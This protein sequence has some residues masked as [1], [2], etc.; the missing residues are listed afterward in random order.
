MLGGGQKQN[1]ERH[2][3]F[4]SPEQVQTDLSASKTRSFIYP[5]A[6]NQRA[7]QSSI[8]SLLS[9]NNLLSFSPSASRPF[10]LH[11]PLVFPLPDHTR[12]ARYHVVLISD[13]EVSPIPTVVSHQAAG[14]A[15][16][17][18]ERTAGP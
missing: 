9:G 4:S 10:S 14:V 1:C 13:D 3:R 5:F 7:A 17:L 8:P 2:M 6:P 12:G 16:T 18:A 11:V 15:A